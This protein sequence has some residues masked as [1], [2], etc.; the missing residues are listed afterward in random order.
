MKKFFIL[1]F[2]IILF[3]IK[4]FATPNIN[5][6]TDNSPVGKYEKFEITFDLGNVYTNP[7]DPSQI[8]VTVNFTSPSG[9]TF[10]VKGFIYQGYERSGDIN[11]Q[12]LTPQGGP[13]WKARFAPGE[14]GI[15]SYSIYAVDGTGFDTTQ[16]RQFTVNS[17]LKKGFIR[18]SQNDKRYLVYEDGSPYFAIGK[19]VCWSGSGRTFNYDAWLSNLAAN[20]GNFIRVWNA[21]W[22]TEIEWSW[23]YP[24]N[25]LGN[26][27]GRQKEAWELDY[28][29]QLCENLGIKVMLCLINHGKFDVD[30]NPNWNTNP[31]NIY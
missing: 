18:I 2:Y 29:L 11:S 9:V 7:Y 30:T 1:I 27:S 16:P 3:L 14:T 28:I 22:H 10:S 17:S 19:N 21:P 8:D 26:Y 4:I 12:V 23:S 15:W 24:S 20:G 25:V 5:S 13:V 6:I 31:Y